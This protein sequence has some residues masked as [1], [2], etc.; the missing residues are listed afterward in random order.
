[1]D[2]NG[3]P[4]FAVMEQKMRYL[5]ERQSTIAQNIAN[6]DTPGYKTM[7]L[8]QPNF[9]ELAMGKG[10]TITLARTNPKHMGGDAQKSGGMFKAITVEP[11]Y[12]TNPSD[13]TVS[14][15]EEIKKMSLNQ[16]DYQQVVTIYRKTIDMFRTAAGRPGGA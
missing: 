13:N 2:I 15:D 14:L 8:K 12:E 16:T 5:S 6:A 11:T 10:S 3:I 7:D 1:M 9:R 4:L